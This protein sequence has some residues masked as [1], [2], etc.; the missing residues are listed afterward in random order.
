MPGLLLALA[1]AGAATPPARVHDYHDVVISPKGDRI[2]AVEAD[3]PFQSEAEPHA[4]VVIRDRADGRI[5]ATY[6]PCPTCF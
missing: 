5:L 3:D 6:D 4:A 1:L 2:A